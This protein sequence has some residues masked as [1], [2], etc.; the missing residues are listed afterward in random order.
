MKRFAFIA[1]LSVAAMPMASAGEGEFDIDW[2]AS[3]LPDE[4]KPAWKLLGGGEERGGKGAVTLEDGVLIL[5]APAQATVGGARHTS[6]SYTIDNPQHWKPGKEGSTIEF[7]VK[8]E[9][10]AEGAQ[11]AAGIGFITED[12]SVRFTFDG[13]GITANDGQQVEIDTSTLRTY[14]IVDD[15]LGDVRLYV[16]ESSEPL[17]ETQGEP[18]KSRFR[19]IYFGAPLLHAAGISHWE[20]VRFTNKGIKE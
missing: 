7:R 6:H 20:F 15:P 13:Q 8:I 2:Q 19:Y 17:I 18:A 14:R 9:S 5:N 16:E 10:V 12:R 4:A 3:V 11:Y 1:M